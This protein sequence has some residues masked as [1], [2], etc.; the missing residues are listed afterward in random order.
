MKPSAEEKQALR[1]QEQA[2][3]QSMLDKI[4]KYKSKFPDLSQR[5]K[6]SVK[7]SIEELQDELHYI[8]EHRTR[9]EWP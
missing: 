9:Q 3:K 8:E 7:S 2:Q 4:G 6:V 1:E 5:N